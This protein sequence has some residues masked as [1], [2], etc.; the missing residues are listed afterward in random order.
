MNENKQ[1]FDITQFSGNQQAAS[2]LTQTQYPSDFQTLLLI[3]YYLDPKLKS[4]EDFKEYVQSEQVQKEYEKIEAET[5]AGKS[6]DALSDKR[7]KGIIDLI[8]MKDYHGA[9]VLIDEKLRTD[10]VNG[11]LRILKIISSFNGRNP[12]IFPCNEIK[13]SLDALACLAQNQQV[14]ILAGTIHNIIVL[15]FKQVHGIKFKLIDTKNANRQIMD[16]TT[17]SILFNLNAPKSIIYEAIN[18]SGEYKS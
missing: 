5:D 7:L 16:K 1:N 10:P 12:A 11:S 14:G 2:L 15:T 18:L 8:E 6:H 17:L 4:F 13:T 3:D 9:G